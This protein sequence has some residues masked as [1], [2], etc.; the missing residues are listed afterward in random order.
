MQ[1]DLAEHRTAPRTP[2]RIAPPPRRVP[3]TLRARVLFGGFAVF[4]WLWFGFGSLLATPFVRMG[5]VSSWLLFREGVVSVA[6]EVVGCRSTGAS[7]GG[8]KGRSGTPIYENDYRYVVHEQVFTG[9]SY[10]LGDCRDAGAE[11]VVEHLEGRPEVS[12]I[13]GMRRAPFGPG[14]LFIL[15]FPVVGIALV[16][17][18]LRAGLRELRLLTHGKLALGKLVGSEGTSVS[19]NKRRVMKMRFGI[20]TETGARHEVSVKTHLTERLED[21]PRERILYDPDRPGVALGWDVLAGGP[22]LDM[23]GALEG[24]GARALLYVLPPLLAIAAVVLALRL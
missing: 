12:R 15:V 11:V 20:E 3:F 23:T 8:S 7:E 9:A 2:P 24:A 22:R 6:G 10:A 21:E 17:F 5:D 19:V 4:A 14:I 18:S 16:A 1:R 13:A